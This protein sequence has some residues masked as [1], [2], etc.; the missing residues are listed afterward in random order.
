[1]TDRPGGLSNNPPWWFKTLSWTFP[2]WSILVVACFLNGLNFLLNLLG[3]PIT[4]LIPY[5]K[6]MPL[7]LIIPCLLFVLCSACN[8]W[9]RRKSIYLLC[10]NFLLLCVL[11]PTYG[12]LSTATWIASGVPIKGTIKEAE[13]CTDGKFL[14]NRCDPKL[15]LRAT[16]ILKLMYEKPLCNQNNPAFVCRL[17]VLDLDCVPICYRIERSKSGFTLYY[18]RLDPEPFEGYTGGQVSSPTAYICNRL[19]I[20]P[21]QLTQLST[22]LTDAKIFYNQNKFHS[23]EYDVTEKQYLLEFQ[24]DGKYHYYNFLEDKPRRSDARDAKLEPA[25]IEKIKEICEDV[26]SSN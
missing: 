9:F 18:T 11:G 15:N 26:V 14:P 7:Y 2:P 22:A 8:N 13:S 20:S 12:T 17:L 19:V 21:A 16:S 10:F 24:V 6:L 4:A 23:V 3:Y 1:M 5:D 25:F